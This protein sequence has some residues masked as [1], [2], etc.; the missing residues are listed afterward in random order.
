MFYRMSN[1]YFI[2]YN[3]RKCY[4]CGDMKPRDKRP[5]SIHWRCVECRAK[6][7]RETQ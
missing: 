4:G 6:T 3:V 5:A 7:K 1:G 2:K